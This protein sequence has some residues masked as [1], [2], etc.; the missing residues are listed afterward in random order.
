MEMDIKVEQTYKN[1]PWNL[2]Y[3]SIRKCGVGKKFILYFPRLHLFVY[4]YTKNCNFLKQ[5]FSI[6][7]YFK[8]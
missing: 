8:T 5:L 6:L 1:V 4:K 2:T 3:T 7:I